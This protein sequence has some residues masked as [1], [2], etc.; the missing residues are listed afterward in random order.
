[1]AVSQHNRTSSELALPPLLAEDFIEV[2]E[3]FTAARNPRGVVLGGCA[4]A[5]DEGPDA[6]NLGA[7]ELVVLEVDVVNDLGDRAQGGVLEASALQQHFERALVAFVGE[8]RLEHV[9]AQLTFMRTVTLA[10]YELEMRF[11]IDQT[12]AQPG[13][14]DP[15]CV[16][17]LA[18]DPGPVAGRF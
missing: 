14:G 11:G 18:C 4:D 3:D 8:L 17:A 10:R 5:I 6:G 12:A 16:N 9:E 2:I 13:A 1:A 15:I 7:A